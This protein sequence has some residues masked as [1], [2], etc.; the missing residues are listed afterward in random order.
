MDGMNP[1]REYT[2]EYN[3]I[4]VTGEYDFVFEVDTPVLD[5]LRA[6]PGTVSMRPP[7]RWQLFLAGLEDRRDA[8]LTR[9]HRR[10]F[11]EHPD[12]DEW[13]WDD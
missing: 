4:D 11:P 5:V 1:R 9:L 2:L 12:Y 8:L 13:D 3:G 6:M 7:S 10:L